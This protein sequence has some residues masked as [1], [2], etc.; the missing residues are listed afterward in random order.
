MELGELGSIM[1][2][3]KGAFNISLFIALLKFL[4]N[5]SNTLSGYF[6]DRHM[7]EDESIIYMGKKLSGS[8]QRSL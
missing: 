5:V 3:A 4:Y 7:N 8:V 1:P 2:H 6:S